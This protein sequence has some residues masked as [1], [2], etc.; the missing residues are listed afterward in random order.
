LVLSS[1]MGIGKKYNL[2]PT[3]SERAEENSVRLRTASF[4]G[5]GLQSG[6]EVPTWERIR[7]SIYK[8]RGG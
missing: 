5:R 4:T 2:T 6:V 1:T 7:E 3:L 8:G